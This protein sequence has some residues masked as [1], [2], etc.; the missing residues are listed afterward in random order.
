MA[1]FARYGMQLAGKEAVYTGHLEND[2][3]LYVTNSSVMI[4]GVNGVEFELGIG[5]INC[6]MPRDTTVRVSWRAPKQ[7]TDDR[8]ELQWSI[9]V[10]DL[11]LDLERM[12]PDKKVR[13]AAEKTEA[14]HLAMV[15][16]KTA[17]S[18]HTMNT[19]LPNDYLIMRTGEHLVKTY[20]GLGIWGTGKFYITNMAVYFVI[21]RTGLV[22]AM[23]FEL[24]DGV[25]YTND[26]LKLYTF[27]PIWI[28][29]HEP[30]ERKHRMTLIRLIGADS[31]ETCDI[32][33]KQFKTGGT[34]EE[35]QFAEFVNK[36]GNM[37]P[38]Q[39]HK[40]TYTRPADGNYSPMSH[41]M[42]LLAQRKW[43][44]PPV[45]EVA[46]WDMQAVRACLCHGI[47]LDV[48]GDLTKDDAM[49]RTKLEDW[50]KEHAIMESKTASIKN[51]LYSILTENLDKD[52]AENVRNTNM[53]LLDDII[54]EIA[55][56]DIL[57]PSFGPES[58]KIKK[59]WADS[60]RKSIKSN[61]KLKHLL[62]TNTDFPNYW[63]QGEADKILKNSTYQ[64]S[65]NTLGEMMQ[66]YDPEYLGRIPYSADLYHQS[67]HDAHEKEALART[68]RV[69]DEWSRTHEVPQFSD[70][71]STEWVEYLIENMDEDKVT[72][73]DSYFGWI[74]SHFTILR[75]GI[76]AAKNTAARIE[77][78]VLPKGIEQGMLYTDTWR[79]SEKQMWFT[80]NPSEAIAETVL[81]TMTHDQC[82]QKY[83]FRALA[84]PESMIEMK[85]GQPA[86]YNKDR[87]VWI[88]LSTVDDEDITKEMYEERIR[89][90]LVYST[91]QMQIS[92]MND[93]AVRNMTKKELEWAN[94]VFSLGPV[95]PLGE[96]MRRVMF[97]I[98]LSGK[99]PPNHEEMMQI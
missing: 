99:I 71:T 59:R 53:F 90:D 69:Y 67:F 78:T 31:Q 55:A 50:I 18:A 56:N 73:M 85:H 15:I 10:H 94:E 38:D 57:R 3:K 29:G 11:E 72:A 64:K 92:I 28:A 39:L 95:L 6:V 27:E 17:Q 36:Y 42:E 89:N 77:R 2:K 84:F 81:A 5:I 47:S 43:G 93:G 24:F 66:K 91:R 41:Y 26:T 34:Q 22:Y 35:K 79:D 16:Q 40:E 1:V 97:V 58:I 8:P 70:A 45:F 9:Y 23:P 37:T 88:I 48:A 52:A 25:D 83:G 4:V 68:R 98:L 62:D 63:S 82:S 30:S 86:V 12:Y 46:S 19:P 51:D 49:Y 75:D 13:K 80:T 65:V 32:L 96:R 76:T 14:P 87:G 61:N 60:I 33:A 20:Q 21:N 74:P 44:L 54:K 7:I